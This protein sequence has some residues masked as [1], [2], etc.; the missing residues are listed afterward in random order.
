MHVPDCEEHACARA[1]GRAH[2]AFSQKSRTR[3]EPSREP[4]E[5]KFKAGISIRNITVCIQL[6]QPSFVWRKILSQRV[7]SLPEVADVSWN[8]AGRYMKGAIPQRG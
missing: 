5:E 6:D 1:L 3:L 4:M 2:C 8:S 7:I